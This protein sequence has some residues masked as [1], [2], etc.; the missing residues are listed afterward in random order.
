MISSLCRLVGV[1]ITAFIEYRDLKAGY[2]L[3]RAKE[4]IS[5]FQAGARGVF[6][7][8]I[9]VKTVSVKEEFRT[10]AATVI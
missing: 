3:G 5:I 1:V 2:D 8:L 10:E 4:R 6:D 7:L 9:A